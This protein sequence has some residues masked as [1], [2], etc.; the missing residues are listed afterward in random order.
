MSF[1]G[2]ANSKISAI[3]NEAAQTAAYLGSFQTHLQGNAI[4]LPT[5]VSSYL[6]WDRCGTKAA[7]N[8]APAPQIQLR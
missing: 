5:A 4:L 6:R 3:K 7:N 8:S 2:D 1:F